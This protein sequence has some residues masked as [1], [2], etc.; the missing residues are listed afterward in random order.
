MR[1]FAR[2]ACQSNLTGETIAPGAFYAVAPAPRVQPSPFLRRGR[3]RT[4]GNAQTA[5]NV[6]ANSRGCLTTSFGTLFR[7]GASARIRGR[8]PPNAGTL[9]VRFA[10]DGE[11]DAPTSANGRPRM[12][13]LEVRLAGSARGAFTAAGSRAIVL[14]AAKKRATRAW[15]LAR[16]NHSV[17]G[18]PR[19]RSIIHEVPVV[20]LSGISGA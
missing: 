2:L 16:P 9:I 3:A 15:W 19:K 13:C 5:R 6:S 18:T 17:G 7:C 10:R 14:S 12:H 20:K 1:Q 4:F 11:V 8:R